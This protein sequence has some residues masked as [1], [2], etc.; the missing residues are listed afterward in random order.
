MLKTVK[1]HMQE[2][3]SREIIS[4]LTLFCI[5]TKFSLRLR[6]LNLQGQQNMVIDLF[7]F[8]FATV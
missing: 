7:M 6:F 2:I 1:L 5:L 3:E 4:K 8:M